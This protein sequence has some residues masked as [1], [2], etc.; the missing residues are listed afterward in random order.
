MPKK[1]GMTGLV[2][3]KT[4]IGKFDEVAAA[5]KNLKEV[6]EVYGAYGEVDIIARVETEEE[7]LSEVVLKKIRTIEGIVDTVTTVLIPL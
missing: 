3:I 7:Y 5:L 1:I 2:N 6:K 4:E